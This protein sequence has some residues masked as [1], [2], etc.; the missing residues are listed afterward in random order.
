M[1][2]VSPIIVESVVGKPWQVRTRLKKKPAKEREKVLL[3]CFA[4]LLSVFPCCAQKF[5]F[6]A[7]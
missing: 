3:V 6:N 2:S 1:T 7:I 5:S 4:G